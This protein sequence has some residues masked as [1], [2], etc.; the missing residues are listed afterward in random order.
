MSSK[1]SLRNLVDAI[2]LMTVSPKK[3]P[4]FM[5]YE[6]NKAKEGLHKSR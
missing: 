2:A 3:Y 6:G 5:T 1:E 4:E